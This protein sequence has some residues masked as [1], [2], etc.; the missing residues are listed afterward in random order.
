M[1]IVV[2]VVMLNNMTTNKQFLQRCVLLKSK[3]DKYKTRNGK[4]HFA[5][6]LH[7]KGI[8]NEMKPLVSSSETRQVMTN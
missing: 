5:V 8:S 4:L 7:Q 2:V 1:F 3:F 6:F